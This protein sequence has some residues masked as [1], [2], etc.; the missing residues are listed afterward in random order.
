MNAGKISEILALQVVGY[1][2][3]KACFAVKFL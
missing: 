3:T 1:R 2:A